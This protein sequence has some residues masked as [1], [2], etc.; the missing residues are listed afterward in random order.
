MKDISCITIPCLV[1]NGKG[2]EFCKDTKVNNY[3]NLPGSLEL[4]KSEVYKFIA[5]K[6]LASNPGI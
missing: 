2:C 6:K 4:L 5:N 3:A 1:C